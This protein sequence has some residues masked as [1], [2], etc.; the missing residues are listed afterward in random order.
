M[1][2]VQVYACAGGKGK[3]LSRGLARSNYKIKGGVVGAGSAGRMRFTSCAAGPF[4][5]T[6]IFAPCEGPEILPSYLNSASNQRQNATMD[7]VIA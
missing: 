2:V 6:D 3:R 4:S 1:G 5:G 7:Q